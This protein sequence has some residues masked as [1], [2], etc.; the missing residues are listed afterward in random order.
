MADLLDFGVSVASKSLATDRFSVDLFSAASRSKT[1]RASANRTQDTNDGG[2]WDHTGSHTHS[3]GCSWWSVW[4][5]QCWALPAQSAWTAPPGTTLLLPPSAPCKHSHHWEDPTGLQYL[6]K[7]DKPTKAPG[8]TKETNH[9]EGDARVSTKFVK[10]K[11][12]K[13]LWQTID[14]LQQEHL[15]QLEFELIWI[16]I[17]SF[18]SRHR[19][20]LE[21]LNCSTINTISL[22]FSKFYSTIIKHI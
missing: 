22:N 12:E 17:N 16:S 4:S 21:W 20:L 5:R 10:F 2:F 8:S 3:T 1:Q 15:S 13:K 18:L 7:T 19:K 14:Y 9:S 11:Q 6:F